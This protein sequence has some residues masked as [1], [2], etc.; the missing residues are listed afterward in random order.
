M[1]P[2]ELEDVVAVGII[3]GMVEA[4]KPGRTVTVEK[5]TL[6]PCGKAHDGRI[7]QANTQRM[8]KLPLVNIFL[9]FIR[10]L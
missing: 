3:E 2:T 8:G 4:A 7:K 5:Y 1:G 6:E 10:C 9:V